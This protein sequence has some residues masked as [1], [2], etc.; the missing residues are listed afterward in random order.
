ML[1]HEIHSGYSNI[2]QTLAHVRMFDRSPAPS[3][4]HYAGTLRTDSREFTTS[5]LRHHRLLIKVA[6]E[7]RLTDSLVSMLYVSDMRRSPPAEKVAL[8]R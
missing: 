4:R 2:K 3:E 1:Y 8:R 5:S 7:S 6:Q